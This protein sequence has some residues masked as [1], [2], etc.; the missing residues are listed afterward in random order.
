MKK[1]Q[2]IWRSFYKN[3]IIKRKFRSYWMSFMD[4]EYRAQINRL[5]DLTKDSKGT[6]MRYV[7]TSLLV[8]GHKIIYPKYT[9]SLMLDDT[10]KLEPI[11]VVQSYGKYIVIDGNHRLPAII[12]RAE[13]LK[14]EWTQCEVII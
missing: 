10:T 5:Y 13:R 14:T 1:W 2:R 4:S 8:H 12:A 9:E 3:I 6:E 11:K 7:R